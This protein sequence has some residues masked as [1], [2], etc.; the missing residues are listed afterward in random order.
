[1]GNYVNDEI[2]TIIIAKCD[3]KIYKLYLKSFKNYRIEFPRKAKVNLH[4]SICP[5]TIFDVQPKEM[6]TTT[7]LDFICGDT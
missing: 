7:F 1:M 5:K 4:C 2:I 6:L 3:I